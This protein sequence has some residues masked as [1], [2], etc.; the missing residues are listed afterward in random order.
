MQQVWIEGSRSHTAGNVQDWE[1]WLRGIAANRNFMKNYA[2]TRVLTFNPKC[3]V[4]ISLNLMTR[5]IV[6][7]LKHLTSNKNIPETLRTAAQ[8]LFRQLFPL[9]RI[10]GYCF[11]EKL[12]LGH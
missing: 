2:V 1:A 11:G 8:K 7:D 10:Q 9:R 5:L 3:P 6:T 4:D 12:L